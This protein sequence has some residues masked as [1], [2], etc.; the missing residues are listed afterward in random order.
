MSHPNQ[1]LVSLGMPHTRNRIQCRCLPGGH[2]VKLN[3]HAHDNCND[4]KQE[5]ILVWLINIT[6]TTHYIKH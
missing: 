3:T 5:R 6:Y 1:Q 2:Y 4:G